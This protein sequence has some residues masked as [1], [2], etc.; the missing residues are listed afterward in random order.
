[1][2]LYIYELLSELSEP[3]EIATPT[4]IQIMNMRELIAYMANET[5]ANILAELFLDLMKANPKSQTQQTH[6][7]KKKLRVRNIK[8]EHTLQL[9]EEYHLQLV[10][11]DERW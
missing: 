1:M 6:H 2:Y 4:I 8:K 9:L 7:P 10:L 11:S 5:Q 3:A